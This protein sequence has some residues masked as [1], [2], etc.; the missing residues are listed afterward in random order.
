MATNHLVL[1]QPQSQRQFG[2]ARLGSVQGDEPC[3]VS[4]GRSDLPTPHRPTRVDTGRQDKE[5]LM[6]DSA[7][8]ATTK[9]IEGLFKKE[10]GSIG[11]IERIRNRPAPK[12]VL[13]KKEE[14]PVPGDVIG[15]CAQRSGY[16]PPMEQP[17]YDGFWKLATQD[18]KKQGEKHTK[19]KCKKASNRSNTV[20][21][22]SN[23]TKKLGGHHGKSR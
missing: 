1:R 17:K 22:A 7:I 8:E 5:K 3:P 10:T 14:E 12:E 16:L 23:N 13:Q 6:P 9:Y 15:A 19:R 2:P 11:L 20:K 18:A 4:L 21:R